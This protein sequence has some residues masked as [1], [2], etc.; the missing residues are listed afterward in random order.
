MRQNC[1]CCSCSSQC[2]P[3]VTA[4]YNA[5]FNAGHCKCSFGL[6]QMQFLECSCRFVKCSCSFENA[7][8]VFTAV[9]NAGHFKCSFAPMQMQFSNAV[10]VMQ[11]AVAV[12]NAVSHCR[13]L[14]M[15]VF[16]NAVPPA[17]KNCIASQTCN[18][19]ETATAVGGLGGRLIP[20]VNHSDRR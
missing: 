11:N 9:F 16:I 14:Q 7:D 4:V 6:M 10:A 2:S 19:V 13:S 17:V 3:I 12:F 8:A 20:G 1:N 18:A 5:V 15:Q